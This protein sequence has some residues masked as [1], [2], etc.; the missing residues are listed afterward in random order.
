MTEALLPIIPAALL[1]W[2]LPAPAFTGGTLWGLTVKFSGAFA[3][4]F[5][6]FLTL[7]SKAPPPP[8]LAKPPPAQQEWQAWALTGRVRYGNSNEELPPSSIR[9]DLEPPEIT[10]N[11]DGTFD[12][13][14]MVKPGPLGKPEFPRVLAEAPSKKYGTQT[15]ELDSDAATG[16][17]DFNV[18]RDDARHVVNIGNPIVLKLIPD[19]V[20]TV[21]PAP[22]PRALQT[23]IHR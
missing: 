7:L 5:V 12:A 9:V 20:P 19:S 13:D 2:K 22:I 21:A 18:T 14:L 16:E 10:V 3:G 6:I 4:Y 8:V 17:N 11:P 1:F 15:I 23:A